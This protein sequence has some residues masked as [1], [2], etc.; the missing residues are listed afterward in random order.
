MKLARWWS[1]ERQE[2]YTSTLPYWNGCFPGFDRQEDP[3]YR[4]DKL[5]GWIISPSLALS[6]SSSFRD[7]WECWSPTREDNMAM[8]ST[9]SSGGPPTPPPGYSCFRR[10][11]FAWTSWASGRLPLR[12]WYSPS[13]EEHILIAGYTSYYSEG[14]FISHNFGYVPGPGEYD[15]QM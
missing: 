2:N 8:E 15:Q 13:R 6:G 10:L 11:G 3:Q 5:E 4:Y 7:I 14:Y 9:S 12:Q 1:S